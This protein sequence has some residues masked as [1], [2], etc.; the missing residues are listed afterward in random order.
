MFDYHKNF[1]Q[2]SFYNIRICKSDDSEVEKSLERYK[3]V[4]WWPLVGQY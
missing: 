2:H 3:V 4:L 1:G